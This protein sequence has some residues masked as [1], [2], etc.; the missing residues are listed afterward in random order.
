MN[1]S[2]EKAD[3]LML[4]IPLIDLAQK[5]F[6][7]SKTKIVCPFHEDNKPSMQLYQNHKSVVAYCFGCGRRY[8]LVDVFSKKS[9]GRTPANVY[10]LE[11][12]YNDMMKRL[13]LDRY[14]VVLEEEDATKFR[15]LSAMKYLLKKYTTHELSKAAI[16]FLTSKGIYSSDLSYKYNIIELKNNFSRAEVAKELS[17]KFKLDEEMI[18]K[19][20]V[21]F[22]YK[23]L[24]Y[25]IH[26]DVGNPI[27]FVSRDLTGSNEYKYINSGN[28][29]L[30]QKSRVLYGMNIAS[31]Q[32]KVSNAKELIVVEG[33]N[34]AIALWE[35]GFYNTVALG[36]TALTDYMMEHI[37]SWGYTSLLL[38][39][40][41]DN[42]G[43]KS[44]IHAINGPIAKAK[45]L[46]T[47][48]TLP[49]GKDIDEVLRDDEHG[50][51]SLPVMTA[52]EFLS[53][54]GDV[55]SLIKYLANYDL[56]DIENLVLKSELEDGDKYRILYECA[57]IK[58]EQQNDLISN[59]I[60]LLGGS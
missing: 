26:D 30:Y 19:V 50:F 12:T 11:D 16:A 1:I 55:H 49:D 41:G 25:T 35:H 39:L 40:D 27:A 7:E 2:K 37:K 56:A 48:K 6:N 32:P 18:S 60:K 28:S 4:D 33:Y 57:K 15:Y 13:G 20:L 23:R 22:Q 52:F 17:E 29:I 5:L 31:G 58:I 21:P 3:I 45:M 44:M 9:R 59:A 36:G 38:M 10:E 14:T 46:V 43:I 47:L 51:Y 8:S 54:H 53:R 24:I 42:A 34:D